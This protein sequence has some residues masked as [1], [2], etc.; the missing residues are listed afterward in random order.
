M[1]DLEG[2]AEAIALFRAIG[3]EEVA[4]RAALET[5]ILDRRA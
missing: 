3:L 2:L 1:G 5:M 4:R